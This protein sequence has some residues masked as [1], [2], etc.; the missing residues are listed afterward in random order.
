MS[1]SGSF[2]FERDTP[3]DERS[4]WLT[5][6]YA[7]SPRS[8]TRFSLA[9][10]LSEGPELLRVNRQFRDV[11]T[12]RGDTLTYRE[13]MGGHDWVCWYQLLPAMLADVLTPRPPGPRS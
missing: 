3:H 10:G 13:Y 4:E 1:S 9:V 2:W 11:L 7:R 12:A 5:S 8:T 6:A